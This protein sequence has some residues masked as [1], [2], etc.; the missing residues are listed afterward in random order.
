MCATDKFFNNL[1]SWYKYRYL[2]RNNQCRAERYKWYKYQQKRYILSQGMYQN[3]SIIY[4]IVF[5][6]SSNSSYMTKQLRI[7]WVRENVRLY[8]YCGLVTTVYFVSLLRLLRVV[9][10]SD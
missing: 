3:S 1:E 4:S 2:Y 9:W 10:L 6:L 8:N 7:Y 5:V